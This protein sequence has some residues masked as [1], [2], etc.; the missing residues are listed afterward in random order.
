MVLLN[1]NDGRRK[2]LKKRGGPRRILDHRRVA[3]AAQRL[4]SDARDGT[5]RCGGRGPAPPVFLPEHHE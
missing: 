3:N 1:A 2:G 4:D 5:V